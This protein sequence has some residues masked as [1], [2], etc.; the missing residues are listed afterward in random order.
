MIRVTISIILLFFSPFLRAQE[1][2][3]TN[4]SAFVDPFIGTQGNGNT[5]PGATYPFGMVKLGPDCDDLS[6]NMGYKATGKIRGFS[7]LHV[8][9]TG[10]GPKY[11]NVLVYPFTGDVRIDGYGS[12]RGKETAT[13]GYFSAELKESNILA[14]LTTTPKTGIHWYTFKNAGPAG[15]LIDA[16]SILGKN[17]CCHEEQKLLGSEIEIRSNT[18]IAGYNRVSGGWN[19]GEPFTVYF[20]AQVN[21]PAPPLGL[22][23]PVP[24]IRVL[25][26]NMILVSL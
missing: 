17:A 16:G 19:M 3:Q 2:L 5:F 12:D 25:K 14:E 1:N 13:A 9:G 23:K 20:Y 10:G 4:L 6:T 26:L 21:T 22:G 24:N 11:G 15:I 7:H 18:E 8:S